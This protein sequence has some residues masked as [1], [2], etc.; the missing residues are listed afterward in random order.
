MP[1]LIVQFTKCC[2]NLL[3][4]EASERITNT[5]WML[6]DVQSAAAIASHAPIL[7]LNLPSTTSCLS[8]LSSAARVSGPE[9]VISIRWCR[10][11][12]LSLG[13]VGIKLDVVQ[14]GWSQ[15]SFDGIS[16]HVYLCCVSMV[17]ARLSPKSLRTTAVL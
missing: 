16:E 15:V 13:I 5:S 14:L 12:C 2:G 6:S 4:T 17:A 3:L 10:S 8:G 9:N 1:S 11:R 7:H